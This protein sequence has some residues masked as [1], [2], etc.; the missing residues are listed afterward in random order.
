M[1]NFVMLLY[2]HSLYDIKQISYVVSL[3]CLLIRSDTDWVLFVVPDGCQEVLGTLRLQV[4]EEADDGD[5]VVLNEL[6]NLKMKTVFI[7]INKNSKNKVIKMVQS[8]GLYQV[9]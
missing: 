2:G 4:L 5:V 1:E 6:G 3:E 9:L 7:K 8:S